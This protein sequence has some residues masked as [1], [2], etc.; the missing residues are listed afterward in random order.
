MSE[1]GQKLEENG[2]LEARVRAL[3]INSQTETESLTKQVN[4]SPSVLASG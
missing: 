3:Q 1:H 2:K 4:Y